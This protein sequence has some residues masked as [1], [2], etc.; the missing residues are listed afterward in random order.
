VRLA[1]LVA[2]V[3]CGR[4]LRNLNARPGSIVRARGGGATET[5]SF[6][7]RSSAIC[8]SLHFVMQS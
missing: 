5:T 8:D 3:E 2:S 1:G 4:L 6:V 7:S